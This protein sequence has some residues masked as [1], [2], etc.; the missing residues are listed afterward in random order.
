MKTPATFFLAIS[1]ILLSATLQAQSSKIRTGVYS[2]GYGTDDEGAC[3]QIVI[4]KDSQGR[5]KFT[6]ESVTPTGNIASLESK[7]WQTLYG[8]KLTYR[9]DMGDGKYYEVNMYFE[10]D[11]IFVKDDFSHGGIGLFG[12]N[13][14][15]GGTYTYEGSNYV[16][17]GAYM[18]SVL[19][20]GK[21]AALPVFAI[22]DESKTQYVHPL[23]AEAWDGG[24]D[25]QV[26]DAR[27]V[28]FKQNLQ[29]VGGVKFRKT[30]ADKVGTVMPRQIDEVTGV[31]C[32]LFIDSE[33][34]LSSVNTMF[35]GYNPYEIKVLLAGNDY[36]ASHYF[37]PFSRWKHPE[38]VKTY[39]QE[40]NDRMSQI[41]GRKVSSSKYVANSRDDDNEELILLNF[42]VKKDKCMYALV[43]MSGSEIVAS[44]KEEADVI[45]YDGEMLSPWGVDA[46]MD[47]GIPDVISI[48]KD[49]S[50]DLDIFL[51]S[52]TPESATGFILRQHG[53]KFEKIE[54]NQWYRYL[55]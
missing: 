45:K 46:E 8:N 44:Y 38:E 16:R 20:K 21:E 2:Y 52:D 3:G 34:D 54:A 39:P 5:L 32:R 42:E 23:S 11:K 37:V 29:K 36:V 31:E 33:S 4:D 50:G 14:S 43:W 27:W 48:A 53:D 15:L 35:R 28:I 9:E 12:M 10:M 41:F 25:R 30:N 1:A 24:R 6:A 22:C 17:K 40:F 51:N 13:A 26:T 19:D 49:S 7:D 55:D 18:H 47:F